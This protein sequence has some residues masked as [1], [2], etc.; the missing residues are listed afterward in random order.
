MQTPSRSIVVR[1]EKRRV[2][3]APYLSLR[4]GGFPCQSSD[5]LPLPT[6][7]VAG[8]VGCSDNSHSKPALPTPKPREPTMASSFDSLA[9][10]T[11]DGQKYSYHRLSAV[12]KQFPQVAR[13]PVT[14]RIL[15]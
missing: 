14:Q 12:E 9:T 7:R 10:L 6:R 5:R 11:V 3:A 15:L 8:T 13:L 4:C 1:V 2:K